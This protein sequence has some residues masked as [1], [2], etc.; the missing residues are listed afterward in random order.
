MKTIKKNVVN[1]LKG[2]LSAAKRNCRDLESFISDRNKKM[3]E[4]REIVNSLTQAN[5]SYKLLFGSGE[6]LNESVVR[7]YDQLKSK[8]D[9]IKVA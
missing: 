5:N 3:S 6:H 1:S 2:K 9:K 8:Y 4:L 7:M